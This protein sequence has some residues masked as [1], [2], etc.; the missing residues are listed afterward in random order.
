MLNHVQLIPMTLPVIVIRPPLSL[1]CSLQ[2]MLTSMT[3]Q[4]MP[5]EKGGE[6][7]AQTLWVLTLAQP[8]RQRCTGST[9][10]RKQFFKWPSKRPR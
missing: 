4:L 5:D 2:L 9:K 8:P 7:K 3:R 1:F 10:Q 6:L